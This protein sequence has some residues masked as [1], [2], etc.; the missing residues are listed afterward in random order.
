[1]TDL[2]ASDTFKPGTK[3]QGSSGNATE[4]QYNAYEM[5]PSDQ[6]QN[7]VSTDRKRLLAL[8]TS[9]EARTG[10]TYIRL[11]RRLI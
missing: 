6:R 5:S 3:E 4:D 2:L 10:K 7:H 9:E 1:L 8:S 11:Y